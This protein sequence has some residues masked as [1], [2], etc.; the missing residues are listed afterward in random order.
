MPPATAARSGAAAVIAR[1]LSAV[2]FKG[3]LPRNAMGVEGVQHISAAICHLQQQHSQQQHQSS[4]SS[5]TNACS[6]VL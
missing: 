3:R 1:K 2:K 5:S 6:A 4:S